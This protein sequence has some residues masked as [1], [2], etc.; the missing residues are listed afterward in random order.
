MTDLDNAS[1]PDTSIS[2]VTDSGDMTYEY[3]FDE[4]GAVDV[5]LDREITDIIIG[6]FTFIIL[7][8]LGLCCFSK[9]FRD[10]LDNAVNIQT[11]SDEVYGNAVVRR[12]IEEEERTKENPEERR[13]RLIN[14]FELKK[15]TMALTPDCFFKNRMHRFDTK[16]TLSAMSE[17]LDNDEEMQNSSSE[18]ST[19]VD[20]IEET[21]ES[22]FI[23]EAFLDKEGNEEYSYQNGGRKIANCCA[24]C[25]CEYEVGEKLV[26]SD[27]VACKHAFHDDCILDYLQNQ[28]E[29][30]CPCCR[31]AFSDLPSKNGDDGKKK[32]NT[33]FSISR[34]M[35]RVRYSSVESSEQ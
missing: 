8:L 28:K 29:T 33:G 12:Q 7:M 35:H 4:N 5:V 23:P 15:V 9:R 1:F 10:F 19:A 17:D 11:N 32:A 13:E 25:L 27:N 22:V 3:Y 16:E 26:W 14:H 20:D 24:I 2:N 21:Q 34:F 6:V 30:P 31:R 18:A